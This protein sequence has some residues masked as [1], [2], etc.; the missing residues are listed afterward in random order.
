M[1]FLQ[2]SSFTIFTNRILLLAVEHFCSLAP[3]GDEVGVT[4]RFFL[5]AFEWVE[6]NEVL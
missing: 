5:S 1:H 6:M 2:L 3:F 4:I